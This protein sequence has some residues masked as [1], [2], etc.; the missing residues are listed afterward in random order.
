MNTTRDYTIG[1]VKKALEILKL[2][3][4][5]HQELSL[6]ELSEL[7]GIGKSSML[8][9]LYTLNNESF[10]SFDE[11]TKK[12]SLGIEVYHLGQLKYNSLDVR[13]IAKKRL[14]KLCN[15]NNMICYLGI[16]EGDALAMV[17]QVLPKS[18]LLWTQLTVQ[19][20]GR[21]E[22][23]STGIGRLFL[24]QESD[25]EVERYLNRVEIK[26]LTDRTVM[27]KSALME[28]IRQAR[29]DGYSGN[30]GENEP[31]V[32]SLCAPIYG[33]TG[34]MIAGISLCGMQ[35][36]IFGKK[37]EQYLHEIRAAAAEISK[38]MGYVE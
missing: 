37:S 19:S 13:K 26:R 10:I 25:E 21:S 9:L 12:Y 7:A 30:V 33:Q 29:R 2:F 3:D 4:E 28:L 8:R 22:L 18:V 34:K 6:S 31:Y 36:M 24:A 17:E 16:R 32:C 1:S 20:G 14:Q 27:D 5:Q 35:D 23:Y 11:E 15:R 38:E